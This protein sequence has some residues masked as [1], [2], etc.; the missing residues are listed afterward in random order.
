MHKACDMMKHSCIKPIFAIGNCIF[1]VQGYEIR[2]SASGVDVYRRRWEV[3]GRR[4]NQ[5]NQKKAD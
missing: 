4:I 5:E 1:R 3:I 2:A